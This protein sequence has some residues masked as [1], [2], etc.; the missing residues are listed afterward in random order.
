[1]AS[2]T[3]F[4]FMLYLFVLKGNLKDIIDKLG[5]EK[6]DAEFTSLARKL[7]KIVE[8]QKQPWWIFAEAPDWS[9]PVWA[10]GAFLFLSER[11]ARIIGNSIES[12]GILLQS[13]HIVV[14][15][16]FKDVLKEVLETP[17]RRIRHEGIRQLLVRRIV[18]KRV[19]ICASHPSGARDRDLADD[20]SEASVAASPAK[21]EFVS[22]ASILCSEDWDYGRG[23]S[24]IL[25]LTLDPL[26]MR[27]RHIDIEL[28]E[29][30]TLPASVQR[31]CPEKWEEVW[32]IV[33][34]E[35]PFLAMKED[36][37]KPDGERFPHCTLCSM[38]ADVLHLLSPNCN[39]KRR[40]QGYGRDD[41]LLG[42]I[43]RAD[44]ATP[45]S[46]PHPKLETSKFLLPNAL[47]VSSRNATC[48]CPKP[49][50]GYR[51]GSRRSRTH[52]QRR[53]MAHS[54]GETRWSKGPGPGPT[55]GEVWKNNREPDR[56]SR[57]DCINKNGSAHGQA[58]DGDH[59]IIA[60]S[61]RRGSATTVSPV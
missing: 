51:A 38:W 55:K 5:V 48:E 60:R 57:T 18:A 37:T 12:A 28:L 36:K 30:F 19:T 8:N 11:H 31:M 45:C 4:T 22:D 41:P 52:C 3:R 40:E 17:A 29:Y 34:R 13:K 20:G 43:L 2:A 7:H 27:E 61:I 59:A 39:L 56:I 14:S 49:G 26:I 10:N 16:Q 46:L 25:L 50:C 33:C 32:E 54:H 23:Y 42:A 53:K 1:M 58:A 24:K 6:Y 15:P 9:R 21:R 44:M 35:N 47:E